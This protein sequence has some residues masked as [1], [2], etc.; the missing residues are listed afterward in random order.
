MEEQA[1][2][3]KHVVMD[4]EHLLEMTCSEWQRAIETATWQY[5]YISQYSMLQY[6]IG[7]D[8]SMLILFIF[9]FWR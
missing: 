9:Y 1:S 7:E 2:V 6:L 5:A 4:G 8:V 3:M